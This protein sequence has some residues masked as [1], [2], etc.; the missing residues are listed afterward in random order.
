MSSRTR[1]RGGTTL[2][3]DIFWPKF[4]AMVSADGEPSG[5]AELV[6]AHWAYPDGP[7]PDWHTAQKYVGAPR[8]TIIGM[9]I[10]PL[11]ESLNNFP[12]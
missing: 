6:N 11:E 9:N 10:A 12:K 8:E 2:I 1:P 5:I 3:D 7:I 4:I